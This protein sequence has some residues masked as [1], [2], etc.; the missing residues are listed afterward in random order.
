MDTLKNQIIDKII[1]ILSPLRKDYPDEINNITNDLINGKTSSLN[2]FVNNNYQSLN[3]RPEIKDFVKK[4]VDNKLLEESYLSKIKE[5]YQFINLVISNILKIES[6]PL[7]VK[8]EVLESIKKNVP[9]Q[10]VT[11]INHEYAEINFSDINSQ[12]DDNNETDNNEISNDE[13]NFNFKINEFPN[14]ENQEIDYPFED[15]KT[16][17]NESISNPEEV[18]ENKADDD[19]EKETQIEYDESTK[20]NQVQKHKVEKEKQI[21]LNETPILM[22]TKKLET[23]LE[24]DQSNNDSSENKININDLRQKILDAQLNYLNNAPKFISELEAKD[25]Y[26][27]YNSLIDLNDLRYIQ[28]S[29]SKLSS[30]ALQRLLKYTQDKLDIS[31]HNSI[32]MFI[33]NVIKK[34]LH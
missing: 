22:P 19:V 3:Y 20:E 7:N 14:Y 1:N 29:L 34:Y 32:D 25:D 28:H 2:E 33:I 8:E 17:P 5:N 30:S 21:E 10:V 24:V 16:I 15:N 13:Q 18:S 6:K 26:E 31:S 4:L 27:I 23:N 9:K 11:L 12:T